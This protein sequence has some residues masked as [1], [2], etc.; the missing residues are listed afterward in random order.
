MSCFKE[1]FSFQ[2]L[3]PS[4]F[5]PQPDSPTSS[6]PPKRPPPL[7]LAATK[8]AYSH[9]VDV[10]I[11]TE[12][13]PGSVLVKPGQ[14]F[15][16][17]QSQSW[18]A[19]PKTVEAEQY[20]SVLHDVLLT[21]TYIAPSPAYTQASQSSTTHLTNTQPSKKR[22]T[23]L[24]RVSRL[25]PAR[26]PALRDTEQGDLHLHSLARMREREE[27][28]MQRFRAGAPPSRKPV[29]EWADTQSVHSV[30]PQTGY[31]GD[32][33]KAGEKRHRSKEIEARNR[34]KQMR[35]RVSG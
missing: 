12:P 18:L 7:D 26:I 11:D 3:M 30:R 21:P 23:L 27:E 5:Q 35:W 22:R 8:K 33:Y 10:V 17:T 31:G 6:Y 25:L 15:P 19:P 32:F 13:S 28:E 20:D 29:L 4:K 2:S 24:N 14:I 9:P 1:R 16:G 34:K